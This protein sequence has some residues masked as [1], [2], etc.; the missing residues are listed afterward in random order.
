VGALVCGVGSRGNGGR[1]GVWFTYIWVS[2]YSTYKI[3]SKLL[4]TGWLYDLNN[5]LITYLN[6]S[7]TCTSISSV[8]E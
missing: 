7:K 1:F 5:Y 3:V 4:L 2:I 8:P 6:K